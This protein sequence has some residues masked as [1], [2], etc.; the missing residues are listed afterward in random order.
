MAEKADACSQCGNEVDGSSS[1]GLCPACVL[2]QAL[3]PVSGP[4]GLGA[5]RS[6]LGSQIGDYELL[7]E[8]GRGATGVVFRARQI[9]LD[10]IVA[11]KLLRDGPWA[12]DE[13]IARFQREVRASAALRH[14]RIVRIYEVAEDQGQLYYSMDFVDGPNLDVLVEGE[15]VAP[16][17]AAEIVRDLADA[18][19]HM[20]DQ[21][22]VHRDLKP[23]NVLLD[24]SGPLITDFGLS[25]SLE[26]GAPLTVTGRGPWHPGLPATRADRRQAGAPGPADGLPSRHLFPRCH[27]LR[28]AHW[29][30]AVPRRVGFRNANGAT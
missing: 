4:G 10:R 8:V 26:T 12:G 23:S 20:H 15:Q 11:V 30:A 17:R 16:R 1:E 14:P 6:G 22:I 24:E 13:A 21:G 7:E 29:P 9:S 27:A 25:T 19:G 5:L 2:D 3:D 18:V 28:V